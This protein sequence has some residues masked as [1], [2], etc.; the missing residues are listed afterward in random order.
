M[1][2]QL[3]GAS[4]EKIRDLHLDDECAICGDPDDLCLHHIIPILT[5]GTNDSYNLLTLCRQCHTRTEWYTREFTE[6][7]LVE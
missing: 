7:H 4:W 6:R 1:L 5:G 3:H 2:K